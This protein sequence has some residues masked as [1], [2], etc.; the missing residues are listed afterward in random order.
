MQQLL[1]HHQN[2]NAR[3]NWSERETVSKEIELF[4]SSSS[5]PRR[6][7]WAWSRQ[8]LAHHDIWA[9]PDEREKQEEK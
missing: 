2:K 5:S 6:V 1:Q 8:L 9:N 4:L 3:R 7:Y